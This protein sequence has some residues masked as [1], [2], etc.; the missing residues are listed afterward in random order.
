MGHPNR[1]NEMLRRRRSHWTS[2]VWSAPLARAEK[3]YGRL[4][5]AACRYIGCSQ[6]PDTDGTEAVRAGLACGDIPH[7]RLPR[8]LQGRAR[9]AST[10]CKSSRAQQPAA[11]HKT[12]ALGF[13]VMRTSAETIAARWLREGP[14]A[15]GQ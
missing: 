1:D 2:L 13:V 7:M 15:L 10:R 9:T 12:C 6:V 11:N 4:D 14:Q 3:L 5:R 8:P